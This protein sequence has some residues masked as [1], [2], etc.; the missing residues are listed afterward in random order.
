MNKFLAIGAL[1]TVVACLFG[2]SQG[3]KAIER[4]AHKAGMLQVLNAQT[5]TDLNHL[6]A[7]AEQQQKINSQVLS[8]LNGLNV[9]KENPPA[10][11]NSAAAIDWVRNTRKPAQG[12]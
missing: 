4:S 7:W 5:Q 6:V 12:H 9:I 2:I 3:I 11:P 8:G 1:I 10:G